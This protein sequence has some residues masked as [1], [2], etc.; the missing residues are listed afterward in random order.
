M[1]RLLTICFLTCICAVNISAQDITRLEKIGS[2]T[3]Y[4]KTERGLV[5]NCSDNSQVLIAV[6]A[7]DLVRVRASF[8]KSLP[9]KDH[10]WAI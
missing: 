4:T 8:A 9:T 2:V 3:S 7:A 1:K 10:S 6:L 5:L